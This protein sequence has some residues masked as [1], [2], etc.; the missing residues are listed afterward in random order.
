[1]WVLWADSKGLG[2]LGLL[3]CKLA[4]HPPPC[5]PPASSPLLPLPPHPPVHSPEVCPGMTK[6]CRQTWF[7]NRVSGEGA[8]LLLLL[9]FLMLRSEQMPYQLPFTLEDLEYFC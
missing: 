3:W 8:F 6:L 1:M 5:Q 7:Q 4:G 2:L 9:F